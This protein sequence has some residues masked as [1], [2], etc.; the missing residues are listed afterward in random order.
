MRVPARRG[1]RRR[2]LRRSLPLYVMMALPLAFLIV[3]NYWPILGAQIAFRDYNPVGGIWGS[4][5]V[6]LQQFERWVSNPQ[7][8]SVVWNT[9]V[10]SFYQLLISTP[11]TIILALCL[12]EVRVRWFKKFV[13]TVTYF[14]YFIS[15]IVLVGMMQLI[16]SPDNGPVA[17]LLA[18]I[19]IKMPDLFADSGAFRNLYVFS[20]VWQTAGYGAIIYL[21][22]LSS[23]SPTLY[24]AAKLD[25]ASLL[26]K[27]RYV[28]LPAIRPTIIILVIL[29][30]GNLLQ[31]GFEKVFLL[32][33]PL[34]L[35]T[36][37]VISTYVYQTGLVNGDFSFGT[38]VGLFNSVISLI[39]IIIANFV[40]RRLA[41]TSL[42]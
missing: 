42:F 20:G 18:N 32:Q 24:E 19:G 2:A 33:N 29:D 11:L 9:L 14:P 30:I 12:N 26:Q 23:V 13:Q 28:D 40:A 8:F 39:L 37:Q 1:W 27:I 17:H 25:G 3:F 4:P 5:W 10:L 22:V 38:A 16:L 36:S 6:G 41:D 21:G 34:N 31:V 7:F 35:D 15:L